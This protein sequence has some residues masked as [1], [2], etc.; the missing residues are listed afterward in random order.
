MLL[1]VD[2]S[3]ISCVSRRDDSDE[4]VD[5]LHSHAIQVIVPEKVVEE[6]LQTPHTDGRERLCR[7]LLRMLRTGVILAPLPEQIE[8]G[9]Y[10]F[11]SGEQSFRPFTAFRE[12]H[13]RALLEKP[14]A[15]PK[16]LVQSIQEKLKQA[17]DD[18]DAMQKEGRSSL[19]AVLAEGIPMPSESEWVEAILDSSFVNHAV[20]EGI[21]DP[22]Y[23]QQLEP[24]VQEYLAW[25]PVAR[26]YH[27]Q[28]LL[29]HRRHG[30]KPVTDSSSKWPKWADF[31]I[32]AFVGIADRFVTNDSRLRAALGEHQLVRYPATWE[33]RSLE[34]LLDEIQ[35]GALQG[36]P[37]TPLDVWPALPH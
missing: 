14:E 12:G 6:V 16:P 9:V 18:W 10:R 21:R 32:S 25:N 22:A 24:R 26:C 36:I 27:E 33:L 23:R 37:G 3:F 17:S 2:T 19:Q 28:V 1:V 34:T 15:L 4:L 35:S 5:L 29:A 31:E 8:W 30:I 7:I 20:L 11:L 13:V